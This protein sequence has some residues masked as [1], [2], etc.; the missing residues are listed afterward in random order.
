MVETAP[1][2]IPVNRARVLPIPDFGAERAGPS[3]QP[4]Q[5]RASA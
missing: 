1:A 3:D 4:D 5:P 2:A